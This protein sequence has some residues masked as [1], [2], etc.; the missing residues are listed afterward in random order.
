MGPFP[1]WEDVPARPPGLWS[2]A[3]WLWRRLIGWVQRIARVKELLV[4][5]SQYLE[6]LRELIDAY[7]FIEDHKGSSQL[8]PLKVSRDRC[9]S[10]AAVKEVADDWQLFSERVSTRIVA[11]HK[12]CRTQ[13]TITVRTGATVN[14]IDEL[15][16]Y[17]ILTTQIVEGLC[18]DADEETVD[19][20]KV[21]DLVDTL[22]GMRRHFLA[23]IRQF[24][25]E[26]LSEMRIAERSL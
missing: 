13:I 18:R 19:P 20:E 22:E 5:H 17:Q 1:I 3:V 12:R 15:E 26:V 8:H 7:G 23:V 21:R 6:I 4:R 9:R 10:A 16:K 11:P 25:A 2:F 24:Q 14:C